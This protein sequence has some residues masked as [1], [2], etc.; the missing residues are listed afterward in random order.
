MVF[1]IFKRVI[2]MS[3][4]S[5]SYIRKNTHTP[6]EISHSCP[7]THTSYPIHINAVLSTPTKTRNA[8]HT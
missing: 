1:K 8:V 7:P 4:K 3:I 5:K 2:S 6:T